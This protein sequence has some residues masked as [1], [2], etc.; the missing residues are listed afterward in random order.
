MGT[1]G[2]CSSR[3]GEEAGKNKKSSVTPA[4]ST[5][6]DLKGAKRNTLRFDGGG[7]NSRGPAHLSK[8]D[9]KGAQY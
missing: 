9:K 1:V 5:L 6:K 7:E 2:S 8:G 4:I 3:V